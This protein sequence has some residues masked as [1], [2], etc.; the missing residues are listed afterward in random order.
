MKVTG[1][2][3]VWQ[4][5]FIRALVLRYEDSSGTPRDWEA[6]ERLNCSGIVAVVPV[7]SDGEL[8][9]VRQFRPVLDNFVIEF[10]AGLSD[11]GESLI[12]AAR[13]ELIEET[14]YTTERLSYLTEGPISSGISTEILTVFLAKDTRQADQDVKRRYPPEEIEQITLIRS[15]FSRVYEDLQIAREKGD[16]VDIK[17]FGLLELARMR[18]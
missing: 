11:K 18:L 17:I 16:Y 6:V 4:G 7:T 1:R 14:G 5:S 15:P 13:R 12:E 9:L 3:T 2:R 8:L 10:P